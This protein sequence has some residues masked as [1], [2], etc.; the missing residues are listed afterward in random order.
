M[1]SVFFGSIGTI[2]VS[3]VH[4]L[5]RCARFD[6]RLACLAMTRASLSCSGNAEPF[7]TKTLAKRRL[8]LTVEQASPK[9]PLSSDGRYPRGESAAFQCQANK[10]PI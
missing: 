10:S 5:Q 7:D 3:G 1:V 8:F 4:A 2:C 6:S 9:H